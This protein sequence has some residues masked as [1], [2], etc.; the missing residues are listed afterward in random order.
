MTGESKITYRNDELYF[1]CTCGWEGDLDA[2]DNLGSVMGCCP[3]CGNEDFED[4]TED[5]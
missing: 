3:D 5:L 1:E 2:L 4:E